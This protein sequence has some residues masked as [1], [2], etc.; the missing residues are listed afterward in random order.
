MPP[1]RQNLDAG[2]IGN[3]NGNGNG[4]IMPSL[5]NPAPPA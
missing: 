1:Q 5:P 2:G 4:N 3:G